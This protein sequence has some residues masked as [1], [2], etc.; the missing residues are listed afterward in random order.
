MDAGWVRLSRTCNNACHF[1]LDAENL[2]NAP[3]S[4]EQI[5]ADID[6]VVASGAQR[7]IL[8]GGEPTL[9]KHLLS[10]IRYAKAKGL[11]V[12]LTT[13]ARIIQHDKIAKMLEDAGL[14]E[15][16]ISIQASRRTVHEALVGADKAWVESNAA[17]KIMGRTS[18]R[19]VM[20]T[21]LMKANAAEIPYLMH[22]AMMGGMKEL[23][24]R[25]MKPLGRATLD[26]H[27]DHLRVRR[28]AGRAAS[29][30]AASDEVDTSLAAAAPQVLRDTFREARPRWADLAEE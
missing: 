13:N 5:T 19:V 11:Y 9:S 29:A 14:S 1:C 24:L 25:A 22:L 30:P 20:N 15:I 27:L 4:L 7:V 6:A 21:V 18:V 28:E 10:A 26:G 23:R 2:D 17:L 12:I 8:S 16:R 3:I